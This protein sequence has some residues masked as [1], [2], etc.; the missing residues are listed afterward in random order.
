VSDDV[1]SGREVSP[2]APLSTDVPASLSLGEGWL[3]SV[4]PGSAIDQLITATI[5]P[6]VVLL[7]MEGSAQYEG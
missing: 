7:N 2:V 3:S 5:R 1:V 6:S 4:Q